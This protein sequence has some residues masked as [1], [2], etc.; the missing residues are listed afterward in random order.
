MVVD[1]LKVQEEQVVTKVEGGRVDV[2]DVGSTEAF[3]IDSGAISVLEVVQTELLQTLQPLAEVFSGGVQGPP[4]VSG[5]IEELPVYTPRVDVID[6]FTLYK[7]WAE[8]GSSEDAPVWR[9]SK[10]VLAADDDYY[11]IFA[12]GNDKFDNIWAD[13]LTL[14]YS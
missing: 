7:G 4:G 12:D 3:L 1:Q 11:E 13:R 10:L 8:P 5:T 2:L 14:D 6:E 9:V